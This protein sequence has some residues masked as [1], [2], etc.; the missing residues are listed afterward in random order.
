MRGGYG[1]RSN[2]V[3][4][5]LF[6]LAFGSVLTFTR[7]DEGAPSLP[8]HFDSNVVAHVAVVT[9]IEPKPATPTVI[10]PTLG[11]VAGSISADG[12]DRADGS[13]SADGT[14]RADSEPDLTPSPEAN[15][16]LRESLRVAASDENP[17]VAER[18]KDAYDDLM[19]DED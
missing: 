2:L 15:L 13:D 4:V 8:R 1:F 18:A 17:D 7:R 14:D 12:S 10:A 19:R 6:A 5:A 9:P 3:L 16:L 11:A